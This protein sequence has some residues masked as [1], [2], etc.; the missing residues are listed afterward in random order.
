M[1]LGRLDPIRGA[2]DSL[3]DLPSG[4]DCSYP[5][6]LLDGERLWVAYYSSH[7][8]NTSL[9]LAEIAWQGGTNS[10]GTP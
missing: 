8:G 7:E 1:Q 2:Y 10:A 6:F 4:G 3:I 9:Y 5:G